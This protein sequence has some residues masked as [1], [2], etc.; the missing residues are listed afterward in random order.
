MM[1]LKSLLI[2]VLF[3]QCTL[4]QKTYKIA[5][6]NTEN[7]FDTIDG[8]NDDAE[9]LPQSKAQWNGA[10]YNEKLIHIRQVMTDLN[11]PMIVGFSEIENKSVLTDLIQDGYSNYGIVHYESPDL[12]GIDVGMI[13]DKKLLS[14]KESGNIR[15]VLPGDST[16]LT[17]DIVWAKF[18]CNKESIYVMVNH[19]PSRRSGADAS[20]PKRIKAAE[21]GAHFIDSILSVDPNA[22]IVFLGDLNDHPQDKAPKIIEAR[23]NPVITA[24]S[25]EFG[26]SYN[27]KEEW[28]ILDHI[29]V[30]K[31]LSS[32]KVRMKENS[33]K[34]SSFPYLITEYKGNKVP[35][36]TYAGDK[37]LG[38][39]SD[40][41]PVSIEI[42]VP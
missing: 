17:R 3:V 20:E 2:L 6:Y 41:F 19:W 5:F 21:T 38:G 15:F 7:L 32:G 34:I 24:Q 11:R 27:Y 4:A 29:Y 13:Y 14:L 25:G 22:K 1:K 28:G 40:H 8:P 23:L 37:F 26:G 30:S 9:F 31:G 16:P 39:Y 10:R 35:F 18:K 42:L 36:R 33:G 12:R